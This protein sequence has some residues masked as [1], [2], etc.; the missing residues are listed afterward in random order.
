VFQP[1]SMFLWCSSQTQH[2]WVSFC[3]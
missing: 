1:D 3:R 2:S